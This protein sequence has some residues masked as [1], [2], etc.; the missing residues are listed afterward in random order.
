MVRLIGLDVGT[1]GC[2][3]LLIDEGGRVLSQASRRYA[4]TTPRPGWSEQDPEDWWVAAKACLGEF[5]DADAIGL[6]GQMHGLV[7]LDADLRVIRPAILWNDQRTV[8]ECR[9][10]EDRVGRDRM[11]AITGNPVLTGFQAPKL[12][13][14]RRHEPE[15]YARIA[16]ALLPKDFIRLR[17]TGEFQTDPSD[18]SG[19]SLFDLSARQWSDE[20]LDA[21]DI[22]KG[23]LP[24]VCESFV[25]PTT[26]SIVG[27]G[28]QAAAAVGTGAVVSGIVSVSLGTSGVVFTALDQPRFD[29][30]GRSHTFCHANGGWHAMG[31][32]LSCGG[33]VK[34]FRDALRP[35]AS[36]EDLDRFAASVAPDAGRLTFLPYLN[37][38][39]CPHNDPHARGVFA[40]LSA[41]DDLRTMSRAVLEGVAFSLA[42]AMGVLRELGVGQGDVRL[43]GGGARSGIW[44]QILADV[45]QSPCTT[46]KVDEGPALG[47]AILAGVGRGVWPDVASACRQ[48][49][50]V[51]EVVAP[52]GADYANA[53]RRY[54]ALYA[55]MRDWYGT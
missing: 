25:A 18:A 3:A 45:L 17:L 43:T 23:W 11:M 35:G 50:E 27:A 21:L 33:S 24:E 6:A 30:A 51:E 20:I 5:G 31:V 22:P 16:H 8:E 55:A 52:S 1:T 10:I 26:N 41:A 15:N 49:V 12:L 2:K 40:G 38:E 47:A 28:D 46:L 39:R 9:E 37:G 36:F 4:P 44:R 32:T 34:W 53:Y 54:R 48:V 19:T 7:L 29:P 42:D 14:V 13:W